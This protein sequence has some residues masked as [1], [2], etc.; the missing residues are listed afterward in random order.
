VEPG[1]AFWFREPVP[2]AFHSHSSE[3]D[4]GIAE[5]EY[6]CFGGCI[7]SMLEHLPVRCVNKFPASCAI[8]NK[9][10]QLHL[11][12]TC[13]LDVP[14][15]LMSNAPRLVKEFFG[16]KDGRAICK[17]FTPHLWQG[18]QKA[19]IAVTGT[20]ELSQ[21]QL[22]ADEVFTLAPGIYQRMV[23]KQFDVR[24]VL[25][26]RQVYSHALHHQRKALDWRHD[27]SVKTLEV[28]LIATP[29]AI[30]GAILSFA[31]KADICFGSMDFAVDRQGRWWF[32]EVNEQGQ[33]LWLDHFNP[34]AMLQEKFCAFLTAPEEAAQPLENR[35]RQFPSFLEYTKLH[36][37][38]PQKQEPLD[39]AAAAPRSPHMSLE[40]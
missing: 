9:A 4:A 26:G 5:L 10:V 24:T 17:P 8:R 2:C 11:A 23:E 39:I 35:E 31:Q 6:R 12:R 7:H 18:K 14:E 13:G 16:G 25:M 20:F 32:L 28:Q 19:D 34:N 37:A 1:D 3:A 30:A 40:S 38:L 36:A 33:F 27:A 21:E 22:P 29:P 15:T